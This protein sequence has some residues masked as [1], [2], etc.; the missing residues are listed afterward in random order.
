MYLAV[1]LRDEPELRAGGS[2]RHVASEEAEDVLVAEE[3]RIVD[4]CLTNPR[5]L[6]ARV[7]DLHGHRRTLRKGREGGREGGVRREKDQ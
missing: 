3:H 6:V 5:S 1:V 7:E 4:L 2:R